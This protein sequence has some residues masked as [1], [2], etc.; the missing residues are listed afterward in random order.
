MDPIPSSSQSRDESPYKQQYII[1]PFVTPEDTIRSQGQGGSSGIGQIQS[2]EEYESPISEDSDEEGQEE[3][4]EEG[5]GSFSRKFPHLPEGYCP[6][7]LFIYTMRPLFLNSLYETTP[8]AFPRKW[9]LLKKKDP[10]AAW[11]SLNQ[12]VIRYLNSAYSDQGFKVD[13]AETAID[14]YNILE[15]KKEINDTVKKSI[16]EILDKTDT[17][18]EVIKGP[19]MSNDTSLLMARLNEALRF[20]T[21][22]SVKRSGK[23][24][25]IPPKM[26]QGGPGLGI[27]KA[28]EIL[29]SKVIPSQTTST[30]N[31][32]E[33]D[34]SG[35]WI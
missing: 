14:F 25:N 16:R 3:D 19:M 13:P 18:D 22:E 11:N 2:Q 27:A 33:S 10:V 8:N 21:S 20:F 12:T 6:R 35:E 29:E 7:N 23:E 17:P 24:L 34:E 1:S 31:D 32:I 15:L 30:Y 26:Y 28:T 5:I 9:N 4:N